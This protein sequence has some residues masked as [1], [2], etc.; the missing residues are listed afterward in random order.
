MGYHSPTS[1]PTETSDDSGSDDGKNKVTL[2]EAGWCARCK[3]KWDDEPSGCKDM[4]KEK[5]KHCNYSSSDTS[6]PTSSPTTTS[7]PTDTSDDTAR[8]SGRNIMLGSSLEMP[9]LNVVV[10]RRGLRSVR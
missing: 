3:G 10:S 4:K 8:N 2:T 5:K 7:A 6:Y 9:K 1:T